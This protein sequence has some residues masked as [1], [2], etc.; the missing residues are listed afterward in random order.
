MKRVAPPRAHV[1]GGIPLPRLGDDAVIQIH[2]FLHH[3]L[4]LFEQRYGEQIDRFY[5]DL[6]DQ[7]RDPEPDL[8]PDPD[9]DDSPF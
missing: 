9:P 5:C 3:A 8:D 1:M 7:A 2:D 6:C 4:D